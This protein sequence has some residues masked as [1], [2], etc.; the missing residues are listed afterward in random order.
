[1]SLTAES[2]LKQVYNL[3]PREPGSDHKRRRAAVFEAKTTGWEKVRD[4]ALRVILN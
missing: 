2:H 1:M 4:Y 3:C